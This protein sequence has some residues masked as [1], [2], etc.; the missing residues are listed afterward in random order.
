MVPVS[1]DPVHFQTSRG[2]SMT[3]VNLA[4]EQ[5]CASGELTVHAE[6]RTPLRRVLRRFSLVEMLVVLA[7]IGVT[8]SLVL[9]RLTRPRRL[10]IE[11]TLSEVRAA[12]RR[13]GIA[14]RSSGRSVRLELDA[15]ANLFRIATVKGA[16]ETTS[17]AN[18]TTAA[19]LTSSPESL[20]SKL[21][22]QRFSQEVEWHIEGVPEDAQADHVFF[23]WPDGGASGEAVEFTVGQMRFRLGVDRLTGR[24]LLAPAT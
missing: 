14:A 17:S 10:V 11:R 7:I 13:A 18:G 19:H 23:F 1:S 15:D 5:H 3:R 8:L 24:P 9:P 2:D 4:T 20:L 22:E 21:R 6:P 16:W 12:C